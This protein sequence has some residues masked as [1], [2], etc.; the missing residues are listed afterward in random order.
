MMMPTCSDLITSAGLLD[1]IPAFD[2]DCV[3]IARLS[4]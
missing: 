1:Y 2:W 4:C 3:T